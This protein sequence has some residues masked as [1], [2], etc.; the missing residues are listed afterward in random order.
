MQLRSICDSFGPIYVSFPF[1]F[2]NK[3]LVECSFPINITSPKWR[4]LSSRVGCKQPRC[5]E[6]AWTYWPGIQAISLHVLIFPKPDQTSTGS[7]RNIAHQQSPHDHD[8]TVILIGT[9]RV[10]DHWNNHY[11]AQWGSPANEFFSLS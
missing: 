9:I 2:E 11:C 7:L 3:Q 1:Q 8:N 4:G 10:F 6:P 5:Q